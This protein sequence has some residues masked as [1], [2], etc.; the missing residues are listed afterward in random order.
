MS[1]ALR[2]CV[3]ENHDDT[4]LLLQTLLAHQGHEV[5]SADSC[6]SAQQLLQAEHFDVLLSDIGLSDGN[7]W[8]L[9]SSQRDAHPDLFGIA[10]SGYG[11]MTDR[12]KSREAGFRHHMT[13]PVDLQLLNRLL[14][15]ARQQLDAAH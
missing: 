5:L 2:I 11:S 1:R 4:R 13:K 8:A 12:E 3:V 14:Q 6:S 9:M 10:M 15:E 7:G